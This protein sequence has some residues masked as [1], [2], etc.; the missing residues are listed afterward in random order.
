MSAADRLIIIGAGGYG[1][2]VADIAVQNGYTQIAFL[3]DDPNATSIAYPILGCVSD[4]E[5]YVKDSGFVIAI[6]NN[7]VRKRITGD[8]IARGATLVTLVHPRATVAAD[9]VLERGVVVMAGGIVNPNSVIG[10]GTILNTACSV[11]H[12]CRVGAFC[13]VSV[14]SHIAGG[15]SIGDHTMIGAGATVINCIRIC[16]DTVVGAGAV[17]VKDICE[18]GTYVGLP[19]K[20]VK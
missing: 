20:R 18:A 16:E 4:F 13:H 1:R 3:D 14:G 17:V 12:D 5:Q 15:V 19:A 8:L 11:D 7:A 9:A 10:E 6:G 2:V